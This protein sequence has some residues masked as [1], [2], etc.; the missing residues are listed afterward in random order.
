[1]LFEEQSFPKAIDIV[2]PESGQTTTMKTRYHV[3]AHCGHRIIEVEA[4]LSQRRCDLH[5]YNPI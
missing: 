5:G 1:M 2:K 3:A 4:H